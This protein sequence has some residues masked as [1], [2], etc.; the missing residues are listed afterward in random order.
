[1]DIISRMHQSIA[2]GGPSR[3][4]MAE[5]GESLLG[6]SRLVTDSGMRCDLMSAA[7]TFGHYVPV[8]KVE[9]A[10]GHTENIRATTEDEARKAGKDGGGASMKKGLLLFLSN[11]P[12][13]VT[14]VTLVG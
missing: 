2:K 5:L 11:N 14:N 9:Y 10:N 8:W 3:A 7:E 6:L 13:E 12:S 4:E 1:M